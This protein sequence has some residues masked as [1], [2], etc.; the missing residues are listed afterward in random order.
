MSGSERKWRFL[1]QSLWLG[2]LVFALDRGQ[3]YYQIE[4]AHWRGGEIVPVTPFFDY[5]LV[6]NPGV[7][8]GLLNGLPVPALLG[9]MAA[10]VALLSVWWLRAK[11]PLVRAGLAAILGGAASHLIDRAIY[12]AVPDFFYFHWGS[13]SF[14]IFNISD[15]AIS[16]GVVLL[17]IDAFWPQKHDKV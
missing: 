3:K 15:T 11:E 14:Y 4:I 9:L 7:S 12:G 6:W 16:L 8:Y 5:V 2:L 17:V 13:W 1:G 10:A